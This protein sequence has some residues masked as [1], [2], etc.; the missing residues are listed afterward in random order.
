[1]V[2][3]RFNFSEEANFDWPRYLLGDRYRQ[4]MILHD[5]NDDSINDE[6]SHVDSTVVHNETIEDIEMESKPIDLIEQQ[7]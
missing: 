5:T 3:N 4:P 1:M 6:D 2:F 7:N